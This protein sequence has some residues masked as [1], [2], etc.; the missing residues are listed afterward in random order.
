MSAPV[1]FCCDEPTE[2]VDD[3]GGLYC[4][5]CGTDLTDEQ[6]LAISCEG[7]SDESDQCPECGLMFCTFV[8]SQGGTYEP[9]APDPCCAPATH[10]DGA[11]AACDR[12][13]RSHTLAVGGL[14]DDNTEPDA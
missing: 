9:P 3:D 6:A 14:S 5:A 7:E 11:H 13:G 1:F 12:H 8:G 4:C 10:L 2:A